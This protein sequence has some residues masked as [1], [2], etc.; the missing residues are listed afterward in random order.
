[1]KTNRDARS[2]PEDARSAA[3]QTDGGDSQGDSSKQQGDAILGL[4][5]EDVA[6]NKDA[7]LAASEAEVPDGEGT[8]GT[9]TADEGIAIKDELTATTSRAETK[10]APEKHHSVARSAGIVSIAV[11]G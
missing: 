1:M 4:E 5:V 2:E 7:A 9:A 10:A 8:Q 3:S 11:M 6:G